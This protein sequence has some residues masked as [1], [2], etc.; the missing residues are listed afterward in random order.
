MFFDNGALEALIRLSVDPS[1]SDY[2]HVLETIITMTES[3]ADALTSLVEREP[4]LMQ[5]FEEKLNQRRLEVQGSTEDKVSVI[6]L[7]SSGKKTHLHSSRRKWKPLIR[8]DDSSG[9]MEMLKS[10][11]RQL[12]RTN[13]S[14]QSPNRFSLVCSYFI[15]FNRNHFLKQF[16]LFV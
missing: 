11:H 5:Q 15:P 2:H 8:F 13:N 14:W 12:L 10:Q 4:A 16:D 6:G 1:C 3:K 7:F 9:Q